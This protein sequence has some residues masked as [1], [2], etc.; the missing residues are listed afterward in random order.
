ML[1]HARS[2]LR[3][4]RARPRVRTR[5]LPLARWP[6]L[7]QRLRRGCAGVRCPPV[8]TLIVPASPARPS[9]RPAFSRSLPLALLAPRARSPPRPS[10]RSLSRSLFPVVRSFLA[11]CVR[12]PPRP[13][14]RVQV[15][16]L[17]FARSLAPASISSCARSLFLSSSLVAEASLVA[18]SRA[19]RPLILTR[20]RNQ[21]FVRPLA[22][23]SLGRVISLLPTS[24]HAS[25]RPPYWVQLV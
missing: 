5:S 1:A 11:P 6:G 21:D 24:V 3:R 8:P 15:R 23:L 25:V 4:L 9:P 10:R 20:S 12:S 17:L 22:R 18:S 16:D 7:S 2:P 13:R 19:P 14:S